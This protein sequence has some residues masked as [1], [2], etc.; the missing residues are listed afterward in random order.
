MEWKMLV[1]LSFQDVIVKLYAFQLKITALDPQLKKNSPLFPF[2]IIDKI[3]KDAFN[4]SPQS[5]T[6]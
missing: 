4:I 1:T 5:S 2:F 3:S 6:S